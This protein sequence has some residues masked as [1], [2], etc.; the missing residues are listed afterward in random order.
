[1]EPGM[2]SINQSFNQSIRVKSIRASLTIFGSGMDSGIGLFNAP[3]AYPGSGLGT[4]K[5]PVDKYLATPR[6]S[7]TIPHVMTIDYKKASQLCNANEFLLVQASR[8]NHL[9]GL[10]L[11]EVVRRVNRVRGLLDK[12]RDQ[13]I[14]QERNSGKGSQANRLERTVAKRDLFAEVL[15]RFESRAMALEKKAAVPKVAATTKPRPVPSKPAKAKPAAKL[16]AKSPAKPVPAPKAVVKKTV[17]APAE[18]AP[19]TSRT[20]RSNSRARVTKHRV[21][22]SGLTSRVRGHVS[23]SGKRNQAR[24]NKR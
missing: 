6:S 24:R 4:R 13:V 19:V 8:P 21:A 7:F 12:W 20:E 9:A 5:I 17:P 22:Q 16:A 23:A 11:P 3:T 18:P 10:D 2:L 15:R 1:M 14:Q